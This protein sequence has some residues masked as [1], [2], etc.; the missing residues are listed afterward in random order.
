MR[1]PCRKIQNFHFKLPNPPNP[2]RIHS[3]PSF[4]RTKQKTNRPRALQPSNN[5]NRHPIRRTTTNISRPIRNPKNDVLYHENKTKPPHKPHPLP[6][7]L[8]KR[9][10]NP[11]RRR[12]PTP[13]R[14]H[15]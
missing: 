9:L 15:K 14:R 10:P 12:F 7:S 5:N 2:L 3:K 4:H 13:N 8:P 1:A 6:I 11:P